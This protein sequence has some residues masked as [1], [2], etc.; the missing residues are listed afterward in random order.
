MARQDHVEWQ[1]QTG[2]ATAWM[3]TPKDRERWPFADTIRG[4]QE[5]PAAT[6]LPVTTG[7]LASAR[8]SV[9]LQYDVTITCQDGRTQHIDPEIVI[10]P[11]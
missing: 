6:G 10:G 5:T 7:L 2:R 11:N 1:E 9:H 4:S 3:I 8:D